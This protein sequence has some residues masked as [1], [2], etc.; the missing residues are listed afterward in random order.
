MP[1]H[2][3]V[4]IE[5]GMDDLFMDPFNHGALIT[6]ED[7]RMLLEASGAKL[8]SKLLEPV[9]NRGIVLHIWKNLMQSYRVHNMPDEESVVRRILRECDSGCDEEDSLSSSSFEDD[10]ADE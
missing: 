7:C 3:L 9:D 2:F 4:R 10:D 5:E 6:Y 1:M 8:T